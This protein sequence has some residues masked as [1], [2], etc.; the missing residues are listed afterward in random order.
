MGVSYYNILQPLF[1]LTVISYNCKN[2]KTMGITMVFNNGYSYF[3]GSSTMVIIYYNGDMILVG[4]WPTPLKNH[5][6]S[7]S[8]GMMKFPINMESH[9]KFHGSKP[10][11]RYILYDIMSQYVQNIIIVIS[12]YNIKI[13]AMWYHIYSVYIIY[14]YIYIIYI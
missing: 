11:T 13:I 14:I 10:P 1:N 4:G 3:H 12:Q 7:S 5:G 2:A 8:V 9:S 6:V